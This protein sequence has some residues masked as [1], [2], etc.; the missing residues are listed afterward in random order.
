MAESNIKTGF[1]AGRSLPEAIA[2]CLRHEVGDLLQTVYA[3]VAILQKRLP[4]E[5]SL[6]RRILGD[7]RNR[8]ESCK[9][10]LDTVHDFACPLSLA[11]DQVDLAELTSLLVDAAGA[12]YPQLNIKAE[13]GGA[14][15]VL[16]D[17]KRLAQV[18]T[19]LLDNACQAA[20]Q[21]VWFRISRE[22]VD[23][24]VEWTVTDDGLGVPAE[25]M[26]RLFKPFYTTRY[27][28]AG[29]GLALAEKMV[30]LHGGRI[31]AANVPEGGF[32][33]R[34]LLPAAPTKNRKDK[35]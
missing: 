10:L 16:A 34:V 2:R 18:G 5:W 23:G 35:I 30:L 7:M 32:Q 26:E 28:H 9:E 15:L 4:A 25:Q 22:P 17:G 1:P 11:L 27:G 31:S 12:R 24:E 33:L 20:R 19:W 3:T 13:V 29:L 6:E 14:M 21:H 8:A